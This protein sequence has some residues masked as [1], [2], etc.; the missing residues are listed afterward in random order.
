M[1]RILRKLEI[2]EISAVDK[3][4]QKHA[5]AV[6]MKR[7]T[8]TPDELVGLIQKSVAAGEIDH[9]QKHDY[10]EAITERANELRVAGDT[11]AQ[12]FTKAITTDEPCKLLYK[13]MKAA[14]GS[15][16]APPDA[17]QDF[18]SRVD[19]KGPAEQALEE[20]VATHRADAAAQGLPLSREQ[21]FTAV[22]TH[23]ANRGLKSR[24]DAEL[25]AKRSAAV[26]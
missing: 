16:I 8:E 22:Y 26:A 2:R 17:K 5:R 18:V 24:Y 4:A 14:P 10:I 25:L 7:H 1:T 11:D 21:A 13:L 15:E 20:A 19:A 3:P 23:P 12:A 6:I 9:V